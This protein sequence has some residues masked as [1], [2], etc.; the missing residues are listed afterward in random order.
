MQQLS[1]QQPPQGQLAVHQQNVQKITRQKELLEQMLNQKVS[2]YFDN[3][4]NDSFLFALTI[5]LI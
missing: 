5:F 4:K 2:L 1:S 3:F